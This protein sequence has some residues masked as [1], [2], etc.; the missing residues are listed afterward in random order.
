MSQKNLFAALYNGQKVLIIR[1]YRTKNGEFFVKIKTH[2]RR[3]PV[4]ELSLNNGIESEKLFKE[5]FGVSFKEASK[6]HRE[7]KEKAALYKAAKDG[8]NSIRR[9]LIRLRSGEEYS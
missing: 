6:I 7:V 4:W 3:I 2:K 1:A 9:V 5:L 8:N